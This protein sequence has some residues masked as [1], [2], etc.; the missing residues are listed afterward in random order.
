MVR[1]AAAMGVREGRSP[2]LDECVRVCVRTSRAHTLHTFY[3]YFSAEP[4][5]NYASRCSKVRRAHFAY[6]A[7]SFQNSLRVVVGGR[8]RQCVRA[9]LCL[10][11]IFLSI[12]KKS[13]QS[14]LSMQKLAGVRRGGLWRCILFRGRSRQSM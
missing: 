7:Y 3:A 11:Y 6:F 8:C 2:P 10:I 12:F 4:R 1:L 13:M 9:H 14:M 5:R